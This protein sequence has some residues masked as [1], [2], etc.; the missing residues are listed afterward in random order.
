MVFV[1]NYVI[2]VDSIDSVVIVFVGY[3]GCDYNFKL[4]CFGCI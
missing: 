3:V 2:L 1:G 4:F